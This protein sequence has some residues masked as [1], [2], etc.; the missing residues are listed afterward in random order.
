MLEKP[1]FFDILFAEKRGCFMFREAEIFLSHWLTSKR[2]KPLVLR[3][4]R[5]VGKTEL[6][7]RFAANKKLKLAEINLERYLYLNKIFQT[8]V[9]LRPNC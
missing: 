5:Q 2:R 6:V 3:G 8:L 9:C 1:Q 7:R 4:A